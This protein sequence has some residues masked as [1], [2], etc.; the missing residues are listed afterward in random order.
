MFSLFQGFTSSHI[1]RLVV[2]VILINQ[3][4]KNLVAQLVPFDSFNMLC[5]SLDQFHFLV[6]IFLLLFQSLEK[7]IDKIS[8]MAA[9]MHKAV[10]V[11]DENFAKNKE[12]LVQLQ[13]E[14]NGLREILEVCTT[15][16]QKILES[17]SVDTDNKAIQTEDLSRVSDSDDNISL[18]SVSTVVEQDDIS[19][20]T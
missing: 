7:L 3:L 10:A 6:Y 16:K 12:K 2:H 18:D 15:A 5:F 19:Q 13:Y 9:V 1:S 20:E 8:E 17:V 4:F 14:N 11:D